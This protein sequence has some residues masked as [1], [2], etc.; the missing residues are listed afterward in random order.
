MVKHLC[1]AMGMV[2]TAAAAMLL[3]M[4]R[5]MAAAAAK[6]VMSFVMMFVRMQF[7]HTFHLFLSAHMNNYSYISL[8]YRLFRKT[9]FFS[10]F[11]ISTLMAQMGHPLLQHIFHMLIIQ[12]IAYDLAFLAVF[13]QII[14]P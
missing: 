8:K 12:G 1:V 10:L 11:V 5:F 7:F 9:A 6:M 3:H 13:H 14:L 4:L 2:V